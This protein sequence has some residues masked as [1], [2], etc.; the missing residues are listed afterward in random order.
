MPVSRETGEAGAK[1]WESE[2]MGSVQIQAGPDPWAPLGARF[3]GWFTFCEPGRLQL[4]AQKCV[5]YVRVTTS[6]GLL[7]CDSK[8]INSPTA[9]A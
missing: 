8:L 2:P 3:G 1:G 7:I 5:A 4:W 9:L 6:A